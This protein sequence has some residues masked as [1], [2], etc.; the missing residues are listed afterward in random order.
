MAAAQ[1]CLFA[2][3]LLTPPASAAQEDNQISS[4]DGVEFPAALTWLKLVPFYI[5]IVLFSTACD[6][7]ELGCISR[8]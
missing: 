4:L 1:F 3:F 8:F 7:Y 5:L 2:M 6:V